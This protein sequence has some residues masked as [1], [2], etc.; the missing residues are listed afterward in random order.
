MKTLNGIL[1]VHDSNLFSS[2]VWLHTPYP[3]MVVWTWPQERS[4]HQLYLA[5]N[6]ESYDSPIL[7]I[8]DLQH[9]SGIL[10]DKEAEIILYS[11]AA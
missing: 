11:E 3:S 9:G 10:E 7:D 8:Y 5:V 4:H 2:Q 1:L 6:S